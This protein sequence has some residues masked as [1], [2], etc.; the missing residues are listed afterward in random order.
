MTSRHKNNLIVL[1]HTSAQ[2]QNSA[3]ALPSII[4]YLKSEGYSFDVL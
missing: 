2:R 3:D 4:E 1:M